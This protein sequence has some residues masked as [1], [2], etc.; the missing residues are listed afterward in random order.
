MLINDTKFKI[1][2]IFVKLLLPPYDENE[3]LKVND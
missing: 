2:I 3:S 1:Y